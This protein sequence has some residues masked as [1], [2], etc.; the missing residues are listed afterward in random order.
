VPGSTVNRVGILSEPDENWFR[1]IYLKIATRI[2]SIHVLRPRR[3]M[4]E[5][6]MSRSIKRIEEI[7]SQ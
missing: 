4:A 1:Y 5:L 7:G 2:S 3:N 6:D